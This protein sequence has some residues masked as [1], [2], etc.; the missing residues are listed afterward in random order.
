[1]FQ[2]C[3]CL[4]IP[5]GIFTETCYGFLAGSDR[6]QMIWVRREENVLFSKSPINCFF[7]FEE[8][9][10]APAL[11][12][13]TIIDTQSTGTDLP[14]SEAVSIAES[15]STIQASHGKF[16]LVYQTLRSL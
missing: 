4:R 12:G 8:E 5:V 3:S 14:T 15:P 1:M 9:I 11:S 7:L 6:T 10:N 13:T 16:S 2:R